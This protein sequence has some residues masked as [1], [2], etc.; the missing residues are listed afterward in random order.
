MLPNTAFSLCLKLFS[1]AVLLLFDNAASTEYLV[2]GLYTVVGRHAPKLFS[3]L[4]VQVVDYY[5]S[6]VAD[7]EADKGPDD[8]ASQ[9]RQ[10]L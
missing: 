3:V 5:K 1:G 8:V 4:N 9:I 2:T 7:I 10:A 6:K